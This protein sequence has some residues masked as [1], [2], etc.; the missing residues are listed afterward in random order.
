MVSMS[1]L[2]ISTLSLVIE[3]VVLGLLAFAYVLRGQKKYRQ[4]GITMSAA[5]VLHLVTIFSWMIWS[6]I[7][8][9]NSGSV[10]YGDLIVM[11]T[12][13]HVAFGIIAASLGVWLVASWHLQVDMQRCFARKK[14]MLTTITLWLAAISI[15]IIL[16]VSVILS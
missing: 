16:Y 4:H 7:A 2:P 6:F 3:F 10:N 15:G 8:F 9:F 14:I 12:L 13:A 11:V 1:V 5:L